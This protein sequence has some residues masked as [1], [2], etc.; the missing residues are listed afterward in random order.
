MKKLLARLASVSVLF[1]TVG[2]VDPLRSRQAYDDSGEDGLRSWCHE[3]IDRYQFV[4]DERLKKSPNYAD[5][6]LTLKILEESC[7][8]LLSLFDVESQDTGSIQSYESQVDISRQKIIRF[9]DSSRNDLFDSI[10]LPEYPF[11]NDCTWDLESVFPPDNVSYSLKQAI[12]EEQNDLSDTC[13]MIQQGRLP[14]L[15]NI[16]RFAVRA[17]LGHSWFDDEETETFAR[18]ESDREATAAR[19]ESDREAAAAKREAAL[20]AAREAA[21]K[22]ARDRLNEISASLLNASIGAATVQRNGDECL[23]WPCWRGIRRHLSHN[24]GQMPDGNFVLVL[25]DAKMLT[26]FELMSF[27]RGEFFLECRESTVHYSEDRT[28]QH[29]VRLS[30]CVRRYVEQE[31]QR[32]TTR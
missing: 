4:S 21:I 2:C 6:S 25:H 10:P 30:G 9:V 29:E 19:I 11:D 17:L 28:K 20:A 32:G 3:G 12:R 8:S 31:M 5:M 27:R 13:N 14:D 26:S 22:S 23:M 15:G 18:I 1:L 24:F 16:G 7:G